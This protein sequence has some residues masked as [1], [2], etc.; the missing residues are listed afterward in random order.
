MNIFI[1]TKVN[2]LIVVSD[3]YAQKIVELDKV[4]NSKIVA[5]I[6]NE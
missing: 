4:L 5:K 1:L 6:Y 2:K 3:F